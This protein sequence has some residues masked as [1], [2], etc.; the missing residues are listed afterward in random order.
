MRADDG[1]SGIAPKFGKRWAPGV[2]FAETFRAWRL[3][4]R[5][6]RAAADALAHL[7]EIEALR[8]MGE[9]QLRYALRPGVLEIFPALRWLQAR[10]VVVDQVTWLVTAGLP[11]APSR[12]RR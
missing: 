4:L 1:G 8:T 11:Q 7:R 10:G 5:E 12:W 9:Q 3:A 6:D 2:A